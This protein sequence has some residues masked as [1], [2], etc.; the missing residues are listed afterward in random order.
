MNEA[1]RQFIVKEIRM[2]MINIQ[3]ILNASI[4]AI[5]IKP[6]PDMFYAYHSNIYRIKA[7]VL[8]SFIGHDAESTYLHTGS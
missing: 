7:C 8:T 3:D 2:Q 6:M 5:P 1:Y 4:Y